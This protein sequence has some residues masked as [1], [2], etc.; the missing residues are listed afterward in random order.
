MGRIKGALDDHR[1]AVINHRQGKQPD[2]ADMEHGQYQQ[3]AIAG[4]KVHRQVEIES[5]PKACTL[6]EKCA[7]GF[8]GSAG[9][10]HDDM[11][12]VQIGSRIDCRLTIGLV[13]YQ[14]FICRNPGHIFF[15]ESDNLLQQCLIPNTFDQ[16]DKFGIKEQ[17]FGPAVI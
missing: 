11:G 4:G 6:A 13:G 12:S 5:I 7:L 10:V 2:A 17:C 3:I 1:A 16:L 8:A 14:G 15:T 9:G